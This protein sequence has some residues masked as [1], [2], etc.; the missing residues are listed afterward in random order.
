MPSI[1]APPHTEIVYC[2]GC[3]DQFSSFFHEET[4][5]WHLKNCVAFGEKFYHPACYEDIMNKPQTISAP[6]LLA[7]LEEEEEEKVKAEE[8]VVVLD[9]D[10]EKEDE[11]LDD[12]EVVT[13]DFEAIESLVEVCFFS[14]L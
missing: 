5:E 7:P 11:D 9:I 4:E 1:P 13:N 12:V 14:H 10:D 8:S 2:L 3:H 6:P